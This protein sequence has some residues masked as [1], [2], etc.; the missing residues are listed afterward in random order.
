M[1]SVDLT[2]T[3]VGDWTV[4]MKAPA[5]N[6]VRFWTVGHEPCGT[7]SDIPQTVIQSA[8]K[9][10]GT[11]PPC[12]NCVPAEGRRSMS[13]GLHLI[14]GTAHLIGTACPDGVQREPGGTFHPDSES[15]LASLAPQA[16]VLSLIHI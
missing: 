13:H 12:V 16:A 3:L 10:K 9:G 4:A 2:G 1:S 11:M 5:Q 7:T 15:F 6:R 8:V 14:C